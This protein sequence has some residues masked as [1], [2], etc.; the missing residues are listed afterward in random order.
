MLFNT[1]QHNY[2]E[3]NTIKLLKFEHCTFEKKFKLNDYKIDEFI[4]E[5]S[6]FKSKF[7][8]KENKLITF[9][10]YNSNF[11][12]ISDLYGCLF[13]QFNIE[14]SIF[15]DFAGFENCTFGTDNKLIEEIAVFKYATFKDSLNIRDSK[16]LSGLDIKYINLYG[17]SNFLDSEIESKNTPREAFRRLKYEADSIGNI[18]DANKHYQKE[19]QKREEELKNNLPNDFLEWI[20]FKIHDM[21]SKHSQDWLL[22]LYWITI[23]SFLYSHLKVF[24][25]QENTEYYIIPFVLNLIVFICIILESTI[26]KSINIVYKILSVLIMYFI[27]SFITKDVIL[28]NFSNNLNPFSIMTGYDTL[29][30]STLIYK[31][32]IPYLLYQLIISIRQNTRRK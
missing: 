23:I 32:T 28:E 20:V 15:N 31:I 17:E 6:L 22:S 30:F 27:Y 14:K 25:C 29:T 7:E 19:M 13:K 3:E 16:F 12:G 11:D 4:C 5:N 24:S 8:F 1:N 18:I 21:A 9:R 10:L 2:L 26:S